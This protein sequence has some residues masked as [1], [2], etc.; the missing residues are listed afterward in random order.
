MG[1]KVSVFNCP[2]CGGSLNVNGSGKIK[3]HH[4]GYSTG[5]RNRATAVKNETLVS[6]EIKHEIVH[7]D[8]AAINEDNVGINENN[9]KLREAEIELE[10]KK[11]EMQKL[12]LLEEDREDR[13]ATM[14][15]VISLI[16]FL[17]CMF[18]AKFF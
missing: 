2:E 6:E 13:Q 17:I 15:Y 16:F 18:A 4:C 7:E 12:E 10:M 14:F 11:L 1:R 3:C 5:S 8:N 9:L